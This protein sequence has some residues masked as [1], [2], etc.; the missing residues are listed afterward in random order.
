M[1]MDSVLIVDQSFLEGARLD[2][3]VGVFAVGC[4]PTAA[5]DP[6]GLRRSAYA[7]VQ[8]LVGNN[9]DL[10]LAMALQVA[11]NVQPLPVSD[12]TLEEVSWHAPLSLLFSLWQPVPKSTNRRLEDEF[13]VWLED[14]DCSYEHDSAVDVC[15]QVLSFVTRRLEQFL[16]CPEPL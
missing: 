10:D 6:F 16:V 13:W 7:L 14:M 1:A 11:A 12:T 8:A 2:S 4:Q 3:L 5:A 9:K 15:V